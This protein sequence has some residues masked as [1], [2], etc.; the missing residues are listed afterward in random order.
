MPTP[1]SAEELSTVTAF[2]PAAFDTLIDVPPIIE[3]SIQA[4]FDPSADHEGNAVIVDDSVTSA[5]LG[6]TPFAMST[7]LGPMPSRAA[8]V[9]HPFVP[10]Y[11]AAPA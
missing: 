9:I 11:D 5:P 3:E 2:S 10:E 8:Y 6:L 1:D 7:A 4:T